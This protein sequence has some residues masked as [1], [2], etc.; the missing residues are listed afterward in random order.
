MKHLKNLMGILFL[1]TLALSC[2]KDDDKDKN[3]PDLTVTQENIVGKWIVNNSSDFGFFEFTES[4]NY[5]V[6]LNPLKKSTEDYDIRFGE[7]EITGDATIVLAGLGSIEI[8]GIDVEVL[9]FVFSFLENPEKVFELVSI[10]GPE[11]EDS[12]TTDLLCRSWDL[13]SLN[14]ENVDGTERDLTVVFSKAGT[15]LVSWSETNSG[16]A[17]WQWK[18]DVENFILYSWDEAPDWENAKAVEILE[19]T[20]KVLR[21]LEKFEG[22]EDQLFVLE[23]LENKKVMQNNTFLKTQEKSVGKGLLQI[24]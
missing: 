9:N 15:Y 22:D 13:K 12:E 10:K 23:P 17:Q 24:N 11:I 18:D 14:G 21:I 16:I 19:L 20:T 6:A 1:L 8:T 7:F 5:I 2:S 3:E 4:G